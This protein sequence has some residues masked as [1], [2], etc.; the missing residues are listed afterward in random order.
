MK[1]GPRSVAQP[2]VIADALAACGALGV[3]RLQLDVRPATS[4]TFAEVLEG[5]ARFRRG[6]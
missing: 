3:A 2:G 6:G 1:V 4:A 5:L